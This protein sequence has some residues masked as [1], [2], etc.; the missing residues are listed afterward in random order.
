M[1]FVAV[2]LALY[3]GFSGAIKNTRALLYQSAERMIDSIVKDIGH[4]L[5]PIY[6]HAARLSTRVLSGEF[7]PQNAAEWE[8]VVSELPV[9]LPQVTG[10]AFIG[11]DLQGRIFN[12]GSAAAIRRDFSMLPRATKL[13]QKIR[14]SRKPQWL[15]P[16]WSP[17][18]GQAIIPI[19]VPLY[20]GDRLIGIHVAVIAL[21]DFSTRITETMKGSGLTPFVLYDNNW[22]L[23]H[24]AIVEWSP[25][26]ALLAGVTAFMRGNDVSFLASI[27]S[28]SKEKISLFWQAKNLLTLGAGES[29]TTR[30]SRYDE[31]G[32]RE[33][34]VYRDHS[35][36]GESDWIVGAHFSSDLLSPEIER[37]RNYGFLS[38]GVLIFAVVSAAII[39]ALTSKPIRRLADAASAAHANDLESVPVL[40]ASVIR[41]LDDASASF[42]EMIVGLKEH[43]RIRN[44]FGKYL[45]ESIAARLLD[46]DDNLAPQS[47]E[48]TI[49]FVDLE[50]FTRLSESLK[51]QQ[52]TD[53]LNEYFSAVVEIIERHRGVVTQFQG[54]AILAIFNVPVSDSDHAGNAVKAAKEMYVAVSQREFAG[55]QFAIRV[56]VNTGEVF[57]G[58]VGAK[59]RLSY[60]VHGDAVNM[61]ARLEAMNK[62]F[63]TRILIGGSTAA[64][65]SDVSLR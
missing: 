30:I 39:G 10:V 65:V 21:A 6:R 61:A 47:A 64:L 25:A 20:H 9:T 54:D 42:N 34:F 11:V 26:P 5:D 22:L 56:G 40:P 18:I 16:L 29:K 52:I 13:L 12:A 19:A 32:E 4:Q 51:P 17:T 58:N 45:P 49:L 43:A 55:H 27:D 14:E 23:V 1:T 28:L 41:E 38:L 50:G 31:N 46:G 3:L 60:T 44:L 48:A 62:E 24:P 63:G 35:R 57:A 7:D 36:L 59:D 15:R 53:L 37:L 2:T 8:Q 33:F